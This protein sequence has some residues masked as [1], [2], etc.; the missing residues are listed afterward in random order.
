MIDL[1]Y[2]LLYPNRSVWC[3]AALWHTHKCMLGVRCVVVL[4]AYAMASPSAA[5]SLPSALQ[6]HTDAQ[7]KTLLAGLQR[8]QDANHTQP[9]SAVA[10]SSAAFVYLIQSGDQRMWQLKESLVYLC[11]ASHKYPYKI[12]MLHTEGQEQ[13][14]YM[15]R[16]IRS[17]KGIKLQCKQR[18]IEF[19]NVTLQFDFPPGFNASGI[20][21]PVKM[22]FRKG[23]PSWG[24]HQ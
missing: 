15:Q 8:P 9:R 22:K 16:E 13:L 1:Y 18:P 6:N 12:I 4:A 10:S 14:F 23:K 2:L 19:V 17:D 21:E 7:E 5:W 24:Y 3:Y 11:R 20:K